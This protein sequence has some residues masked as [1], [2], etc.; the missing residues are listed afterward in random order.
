MNST[1]KQLYSKYLDNSKDYNRLLVESGIQNLYQELIAELKST[2]VNM[3]L[4]LL[5]T[6]VSDSNINVTK[7]NCDIIT[8]GNISYVLPKRN[9]DLSSN[10]ILGLEKNSVEFV[11]S[12]DK[13]ILLFASKTLMEYLVMDYDSLLFDNAEGMHVSRLLRNIFLS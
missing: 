1:L 6:L 2:D 12:I 13:C 9:S 7:T 5:E 10:S 11:D 3:K 8:L 4:A